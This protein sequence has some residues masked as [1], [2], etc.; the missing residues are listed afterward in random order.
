MRLCKLNLVSRI[1]LAM[2]V[3]VAA[4]FVLPDWGLRGLKTLEELV[5][6]LLRFLVP[7]VILG[8]VSSAIVEAG[9]NSGKML[10]ATFVLV[11][12]SVVMSGFFSLGVSCAV[13]PCF[14]CHE[15]ADGLATLSPLEPYFRIAVPPPFGIMTAL[16]LA[17]IGAL[18]IVFSKAENI[19]RFA[20]DGKKCV[21]WMIGRIIIPLLPLYILAM[22]AGMTAGG[23]IVSLLVVFVAM[24]V[25]SF[26]STFLYLLLMYCVSGAYVRAN[27]ISALWG[28]RSAYMTAF[29]TCSSA[30]S[31]PVSLENVKS[32]GVR[33]EVAEMVVPLCATIHLA[34][35]MI[36]LV[37]CAAALILMSGRT[38]DVG[39]MSVFIFVMT[40]TA[41]AAPGV[42]GGVITSSLGA[43]AS[44][45]LLTP[46]QC[47]MLMTVYLAMD[48]VG[49]AC[50]VGGHGAIAMAVDKITNTN[51]Y[52]ATEGGM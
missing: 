16:A 17:I 1:L 31:I 12:V 40:I 44:I 4:G 25:V 15:S 20:M 26:A 46:E 3:G 8:L 28:M 11:I 32:L 38:I 49:S 18:A 33:E 52:H 48:G 13:Y 34:G 23:K 2:L 6:V 35:S 42:P 5:A 10:A 14:I 24:I 19:A 36:K 9:R 22:M 43:L 41:I 30:A 51:H 37:C 21:S 47:S 45:L 27:P 7:L 29:A 50:S 39:A